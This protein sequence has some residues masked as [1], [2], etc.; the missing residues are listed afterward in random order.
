MQDN[1]SQMRLKGKKR[2]KNENAILFGS[3]ILCIIT[4]FS[5]TL[6]MI[7]VFKY[8]A[9]QLENVEV[10]NELEV[11]QGNYT[12]EEVA[13]LINSNTEEVFKQASDETRKEILDSMKDMMLSGDGA[14]KMIRHFYPDEI[15][16]VDASQYYFFPILDKLEQHTYV[17]DNFVVNEDELLEYYEGDNIISHKGIDVSKYQEKIDWKK[18]A[19]DDV[20]YAFIRLGIRGYTEGEIKKD[21]TFNNNI[22]GALKNN[23]DVGV[24]FFSQATSVEEAKEEAEFVLNEIEPYNVTYPVVL[25]VEAVNVDNART[26]DVTKEERTEYCIAFCDMI[27]NAGYTPMIYGNLKTFMML[28][29][30]EQ[31]EDYD[32]W[33]AQYDT[34]LYYPYDFKVW[35]YTDKGKVNG[36]STDVDMNI[37]FESLAQ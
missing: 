14:L 2:R 9:A 17:K 37:S 26:E 10:M 25:D 16:M 27:K 8:S 1:N 36:I 12:E 21:D 15:V 20:E 29:D 31:L 19:Q 22:E 34:E 18:V 3:I 28:L 7:M 33:F 13:A 35:Q 6:C 30:I 11:L 5:V 32:K 4:L 24:Y 23:I